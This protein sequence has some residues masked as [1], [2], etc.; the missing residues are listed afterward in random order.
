MCKFGYW[1]AKMLGTRQLHCTCVQ[2]KVGQQEELFPTCS[3]WSEELK[4]NRALHSQGFILNYYLKLCREADSFNVHHV[5]NMHQC[6]L[7]K[8]LYQ[9]QEICLSCQNIKVLSTEGASNINNRCALP[10]HIRLLKSFFV[11]NLPNSFCGSLCVHVAFKY[12]MKFCLW[13]TSK[14]FLNSTQLNNVVC[15]SLPKYKGFINRGRFQY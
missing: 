11:H 12:I 7:H 1:L 5:T 15:T 4:N 6:P 9:W 10:V 2:C 13:T 14:Y 8:Q 3:V